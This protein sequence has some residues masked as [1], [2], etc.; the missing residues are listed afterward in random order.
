MLPGVIDPV[1]STVASNPM[2][3]ILPGF[4]SSFDLSALAPLA[5]AS[6]LW[7]VLLV[8]RSRDR[9]ERTQSLPP[10][11]E[12]TPLRPVRKAA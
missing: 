7:V 10:H 9:A 4:T 2:E 8:L 6:T 5:F 12:P 1:M 3:L 11:S